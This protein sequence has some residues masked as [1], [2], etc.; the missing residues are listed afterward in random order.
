MDTETDRPPGLAGERVG[1]DR[2]QEVFAQHAP[3]QSLTLLGKAGEVAACCCP[4][5][6]NHACSAGTATCGTKTISPS[7]NTI[8]T[9]A[10]GLS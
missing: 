9:W 8:S 3:E 6:Q 5:V 4:G 1:I 10:P 7:R 2:G